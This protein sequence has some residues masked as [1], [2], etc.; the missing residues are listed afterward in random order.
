[1]PDSPQ[2]V[3]IHNIRES[4]NG[5]ETEYHYSVNTRYDTPSGSREAIKEA[6]IQRMVDEGVDEKSLIRSAANSNSR[7]DIGLVYFFEDE[8][9]YVRLHDWVVDEHSF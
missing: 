2:E 5:M 3:Y 7:T 1:M 6:L 9:A 4:Q 8:I